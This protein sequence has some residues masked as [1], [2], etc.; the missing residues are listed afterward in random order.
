MLL[1]LLTSQE[2]VLDHVIGNLESYFGI[3]SFV[4]LVQV[5]KPDKNELAP[6]SDLN[7]EGLLLYVSGVGQPW[8]GCT[9]L[10]EGGLAGALGVHWF[11]ED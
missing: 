1:S 8:Q 9:G 6:V 10:E 2:I 11:F 4:Q 7:H 5:D 3:L